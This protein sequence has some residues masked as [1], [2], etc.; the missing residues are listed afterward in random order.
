M[1][2]TINGKKATRQEVWD[3]FNEAD[4]PLKLWAE[5]AY[6]GKVRITNSGD[7]IIVRIKEI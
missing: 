4:S 1:S 5:L 7:E 3:L 6:A 2:Y